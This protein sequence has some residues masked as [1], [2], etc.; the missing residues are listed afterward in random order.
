[1]LRTVGG[2]LQR[3]GLRCSG[4]A[5]G[6]GAPVTMMGR[7]QA[8]RRG[9]LDPVF[10]GSN[11]SAPAN[12]ARAGS[13]DAGEPLTATG[14]RRTEGLFRERASRADQGDRGVSGRAARA[15]AAAAVSG[16]GGLVPDRRE[17][18]RHRRVH[19][20]ADLRDGDRVGRSAPDGADD[21]DRCVPPVVG[22]AHHGGA[23]VLRLRAAGSQG[24][25]AR[26]DLGQ[27]RGQ[28]AERGGHEPRADDGSAQGADPGVLRHSGRPPVRGAGDHRVPGA[29]RLAEADARRARRRRRRTRAR[30]REAARR[31]SWRSSTSGAPTTGR[32][33]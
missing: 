24:Q 29:A 16:H 26:A 5:S 18:P 9:T 21:H 10:E 14:F 1:M 25:A 20:A 6:S 19:R 7:G 32:R 17:H 15:G 28:R 8:V 30:L 33:K 31:A 4:G 13:V 23:A 2:C 22:G 3:G 27:A 12:F 11:P